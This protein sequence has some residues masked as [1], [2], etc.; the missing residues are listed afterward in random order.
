M[1]SDQVLNKKGNEREEKKA[2][3]IQKD[4]VL[5][6]KMLDEECSSAK[7]IFCNAT[8]VRSVN[9]INR[10]TSPMKS[11]IERSAT[12]RLKKYYSTPL[13][14]RTLIPIEYSS[15]IF[16]TIEKTNRINNRKLQNSVNKISANTKWYEKLKQTSNNKKMMN[17][18]REQGIESINNDMH[19]TLGALEKN[20]HVALVNSRKFNDSYLR[21]THILSSSYV[22]RSLTSNVTKKLAVLTLSGRHKAATIKT[23]TKYIKPYYLNN[24]SFYVNIKPVIE[25]YEKDGSENV[26]QI[27]QNIEI[28]ATEELIND[29]NHPILNL[30]ENELWD[31]Q[32][33]LAEHPMMGLAVETGKKLFNFFSTLNVKKQKIGVPLYHGRSRGVSDA[34]YVK[35]HLDGEAPWGI[36]SSGRFNVANQGLYYTSDSLDSLA[37]ELR[38]QQGETFDVLRFQPDTKLGVLD[39]TKINNPLASFCLQSVSKGNTQQPIEYLI[40]TFIAQ[41]LLDNRSIQVIKITSAV[42][43]DATNYIFLSPSFRDGVKESDITIL[44]SVTYES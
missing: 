39:L 38:L 31:F 16:Q 28:A 41:C 23:F 33:Y 9:Q 26:N 2:L 42:N 44:R 22:N 32:S 19:F 12:Q 17:I 18:L 27:S 14:N 13:I 10:M 1:R 25:K 8:L 29:K 43:P 36:P 20:N 40:P 34:P 7:A 15:S 6:A 37:Q 35:K 11:I 5:R 3:D 24:P 4:S 21:T 30:T